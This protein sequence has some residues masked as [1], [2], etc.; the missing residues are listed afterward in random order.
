MRRWHC[1][2]LQQ[3]A[4]ALTELDQVEAL[5]VAHNAQLELAEIFLARGRVLAG[6]ERII[7][8]TD[9]I[10]QAARRFHELG[11]PAGGCRVSP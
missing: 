6:L 2:V 1:S 10:E 9:Q 3:F 7:E 4:A 5:A 8:A 11:K